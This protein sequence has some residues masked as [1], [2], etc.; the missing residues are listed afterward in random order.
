VTTDSPN[1]PRAARSAGGRTSTTNA[2]QRFT[3]CLNERC[4]RAVMMLFHGTLDVVEVASVAQSIEPWV[5]PEGLVRAV[6]ALDDVFQYFDG[7]IIAAE[8]RDRSHV[9]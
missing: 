6:P 3:A 1:H 4:L 7:S 9:W 2:E 5:V 8:P